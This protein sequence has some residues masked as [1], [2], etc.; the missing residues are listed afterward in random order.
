M[1]KNLTTV[2]VCLVFALGFTT[3]TLGDDLL[4]P[5]WRSLPGT[6]TAEWDTWQNFRWNMPPDSW[7]YTSYP[8]Q[9]PAGSPYADAPEPSQRIVENPPS[10]RVYIWQDAPI[11][12]WLPNFE[13]SNEV[14]HVWFQLTYSVPNDFQK[15]KFHVTVP[16]DSFTFLGPDVFV[17]RIDLDPLDVWYTDVF[18]FEI[19]PNP[20]WEE[21][22][23]SFYNWNTGEPWYPAYID[24]VVIDT[25]CVPEPA[26]MSLLA[27]GGLAVLRRRRRL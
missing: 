22:E 8:G 16:G 4:P 21:I 18:A 12:F 17:T 24:Q 13:N 23:L 14:K 11:T 15:P 9:S 7:A 19:F 26:S 27:L 10:D 5:S 1:R 6:V 2:L 20:E 3:T 25:W